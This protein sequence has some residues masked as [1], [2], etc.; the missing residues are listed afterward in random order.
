MDGRDCGLHTSELILDLPTQTSSGCG[1]GF[2]IMSRWKTGIWV[3]NWGHTNM[4]WRKKLFSYTSLSTHVWPN[5]TGRCGLIDTK[6]TP[7]DIPH[8]CIQAVSCHRQA[9]TVIHLII[10]HRSED[11][12]LAITRRS[13]RPQSE[14]KSGSEH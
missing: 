1:H 11:A 2:K 14:Q 8:M 3:K 6:P 9:E 10:C 13:T 12:K 7:T 5:E 4:K